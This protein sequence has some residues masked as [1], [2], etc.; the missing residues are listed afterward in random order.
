MATQ[1]QMLY[2][3]DEGAP[4]IHR[5]D[6]SNPSAPQELLPLLVTSV[7]DPSR[8]VR[9]KDLALSP[10]TRDEKRFLYAVDQSDGTLLV[11]D[12]TDP[13]SDVRTPLMRPHAELNPF[14]PPDRIAFGSPVVSVAFARHDVPLVQPGVSS[15]PTGLLCNPN[16]RL[17]PTRGGNPY[18]DLGYYYRANIDPEATAHPN[19]GQSL[20]PRRLRGVFA[21]ATL[22]NGFVVTLDV[23]DWDAPCRRPV[24]MSKDRSDVAVAQV[25]RGDKDA[26]HAPVV[27]LGAVTNEVFFPVSVPHAPRSEVLLTNDAVSGNQAP[28]VAVA[29]TVS[30]NGVVLPLQGP[31][32][33]KTPRL[34]VRFA[35]ENAQVHTDQ[36]WAIVYEPQI[37]GFD[38]LPGAL[39]STSKYASMEL[40]HPHARFCA[41]GVEDWAQGLERTKAIKSELVKQAKD[42]PK[43]AER[44]MADYVEITDDLLDASDPYWALNQQDGDQACWEGPLATATAAARH[45]ACSRVYGASGKDEKPTRDFPIVEAY[46]DH[47]VLG[48]FYTRSGD[49]KREVVYTDPSNASELKLAQCCF[50]HQANFRVR[51]GGQWGAIG[52]AAGGGSGVG[53]LSH[54]VPDAGGRC[55]PSCDPR[56]SLLNARLPTLPDGVNGDTLDRNS[57]LALRNPM[58]SAV[59]IAGKS[60]DEP[61]RDTAYTFS[62]RG[63]FRP[64]GVSIGG[65]SSSVNPQSM[66]Y[67]DALGQ[68]AVVDAAQGLVLIDL[69][70]V[71]PAHTPYN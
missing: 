67:I 55:V 41:K 66:R 22:A 64:L 44:R 9:V 34:A 36:D 21:F 5:V 26:Y 30:A 13:K 62:S 12:V 32:S 37:P 47:V 17:E 23:D 2:V 19:P 11:F 10:V 16:Q 29:P 45:D 28:R 1:D 61:L 48:R 57:P 6:M 35:L 50:H 27:S 70:T 56:L 63:Q 58:F 69:R 39:V 40:R 7:N 24:D 8:V 52:Q 42:L 54:M 43:G 71:T 15:L 25:D 4:L 60:G 53:F 65:T 49:S 18:A 31:G 68:M 46:E 59:L 14:Q 33:E 51:T 38:G 20:G 3:S